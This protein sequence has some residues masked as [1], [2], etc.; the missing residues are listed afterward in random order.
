MVRTIVS[1]TLKSYRV[2]V[3]CARNR[4]TGSPVAGSS[5]PRHQIRSQA[6]RLLSLEIADVDSNIEQRGGAIS[7]LNGP[8][9]T[10]EVLA[11]VAAARH[12]GL[13]VVNATREFRVHEA[14]CSD[15][16]GIVP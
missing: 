9:S 10:V 14:T 11:T 6:D 15:S 7:V 3:G 8:P 12:P 2:A 1:V 13:P 4:T 5:L 16:S